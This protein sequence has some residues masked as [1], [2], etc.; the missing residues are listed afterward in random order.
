MTRQSLSLHPLPPAS[1]LAAGPRQLPITVVMNA[2]SGREDKSEA[3]AAIEK[4]LEASGRDVE[5]LVAKRPR[6]LA[7]LVRAAA[8][9]RPGILA[10]AGGD[11]TLNAV[12]SVAYQRSLPFAVIPLGTFN[13]FA[14]ELGIP[15]DPAAAAQVAVD[16]SIRRVPIGEVN[17]RLFLNNA[18][19]GLYRRLL[20][21]REVHKR[22]FGRNR[23][24][25][26]VSGLVTLMREH[27]PYRLAL[28]IDG[29]PL[30]LSTLTVFFGRNALQMEHLG[31]DEA[32]CVAR[33]ELAVLALREVGRH[34]LL[35]LVLRGALARLETAENLRQYCALTV[36]IERLDE[37]TPHIRVA[38]DGELVDCELPL[39]VRSVP[40]ALQV[41]VPAVPE[42][43]A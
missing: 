8:D 41:L 14:R 37:G 35:A 32:V 28:Q 22:R 43:R 17:G 2:G 16:G 27:R 11:G 36:Q 42:V 10:A 38:L 20:E 4:V 21:T 9:R 12:A 33:G 23:F 30:N 6:E 1:P 24:V 19:I 40:E 5:L 39:V 13:Y 15:L 34:D 3:G 26:F 7:A 29:R 25:A 18:S 31:L